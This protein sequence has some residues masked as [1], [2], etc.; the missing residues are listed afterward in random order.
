MCLTFVF[1][2]QQI[3]GFANWNSVRVWC[4]C[5]FIGFTWGRSPKFVHIFLWK[6]ML[7]TRKNGANILRRFDMIFFLLSLGMHID[8][9]PERPAHKE[10]RCRYSLW[11]GYYVCKVSINL[12]QFQSNIYKRQ[13]KSVIAW[14]VYAYDMRV[15]AIFYSEPCYCCCCSFHKMYFISYHYFYLHC[16]TIEFFCDSPS[17]RNNATC[18]V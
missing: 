5:T 11:F 10:W 17:D 16:N 13:Q 2:L 7:N 6:L 18:R 12:I 9:K 14:C 15:W 1:R 8:Y 4:H 3:G